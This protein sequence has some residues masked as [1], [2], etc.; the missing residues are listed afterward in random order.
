MHGDS[1]VQDEVEWS[2]FS[3]MMPTVILLNRLH[4]HKHGQKFCERCSCFI[5]KWDFKKFIT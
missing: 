5:S 4:I 2:H 3:G 1:S